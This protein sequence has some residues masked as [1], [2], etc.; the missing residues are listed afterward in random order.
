M[1]SELK[2]GWGHPGD[3]PERTLY[4]EKIAFEVFSSANPERYVQACDFS[5]KE[6]STIEKELRKSMPFDEGWSF[7]PAE[8]L[9]YG[10]ELVF[11]QNIGNC[12]GASH[13]L[14]LAACVAHE[15]LVEGDP[16]EALG[17]FKTSSPV[18]YVPYSYG[19]GRVFIGGN[20]IR[21]DGSLCEWQ[22][23]GTMDYG[24]LPSDTPG[25][26]DVPQGSASTGRRFGSSAAELNKWTDTAKNYD[27]V[28]SVVPS[29][30]DDCWDLVVNKRR[31][32]QICSGW[33]FA[34]WKTDSNGVNVYRRSPEGWAHSM[35]IVAMFTIKGQRYVTVRNQWGKSHKDGMTFTTY[36]EEFA[37][38]YS[39]ANIASIGEL[40]GRSSKAKFWE[41]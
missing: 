39:Q 29:S 23:K 1:S 36:F 40:K 34:F 10:Q 26:T 7:L 4:R 11:N 16:E 33:S 5:A 22:I 27:L 6:E 32:L 31:P 9:V 2:F 20:R 3:A 24:F 25:L 19:V 37:K 14:L 28:T 41:E 38:W 35:Q 13:C 18:P 8:K 17:E 12:V 15:I 30:A 21:G